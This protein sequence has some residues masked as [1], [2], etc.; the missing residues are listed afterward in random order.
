MNRITTI[1]VIILFF[2][3]L[4]STVCQQIP[5]FSQYLFNPIYINPAY[6]GYKN[7]LFIQSFYR[8]QW[9]GINGAPETYG[10]AGDAMLSSQNLGVGAIAMGDQ[11]GLQ[12]TH[13]LFTNVAY[14]LQLGADSYLS[15]GTGLGIVNYRM[16]AEDYDPT[17]IDDPILTTGSGNVFY[18]DLRL[19]L[20][21]YSEDIF[22]GISVDQ[23]LGDLLNF[24]NADVV[25][26]PQRS[27]AVSLGG[28]INLTDRLLLKPSVLLMDDSRAMTRADMNLLLMYDEAIGIGLG[29]RRSFHL[30]DKD[31]YVNKDKNIGFLVLTEIRLKENLRFGYSF[32]YP[33]G[34]LWRGNSHELSVGYLVSSRRSRLRSPRYF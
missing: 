31:A 9:G 34:G 7:D 19:G 11:I 33:I 27:Y 4:Q 10:I 16:N 24:E 6:T 23:V 18:P 26:D 5:Q 1:I 28:M 30:F 15:F 12:S 8:R 20:L 14:H 2:I 22:I 32:D 25:V 29:H 17:F 3:T 13:S 21:F